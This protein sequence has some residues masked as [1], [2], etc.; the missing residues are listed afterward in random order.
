MSAHD[1]P[2][3][4]LRDPRFCFSSRDSDRRSLKHLAQA[5]LDGENQRLFAERFPAF[6]GLFVAALIATPFWVPLAFIILRPK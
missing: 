4:R 5:D 2:G 3:Y 1:Y 6:N